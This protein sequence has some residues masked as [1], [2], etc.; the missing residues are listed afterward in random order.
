MEHGGKRGRWKEERFGGRVPAALC[1][2][3]QDKCM[4]PRYLQ[5]LVRQFTISHWLTAGASELEWL[6]KMVPQPSR[7]WREREGRSVFL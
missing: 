5:G 1:I 4:L 7:E 6:E 2:C 3:S